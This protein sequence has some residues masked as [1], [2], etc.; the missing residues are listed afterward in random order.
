MK[1]SVITVC[2]NSIATL[3]TTILSVK[4]QTYEDIEYIV[5][6]GNSTDGSVEM[7]K[8]YDKVISKWSSEPDKGLYD[9]M[10]KGVLMATGEVIALINSDDLFC[11]NRALEKV[12][13]LFSERPNLKSVYADLYYVAQ[14]NTDK[15]VRKWKSG[16]QQS[17]Q[18]G[19]HPAHPTFYAKKELYMQY[20]MFNLNFKLAADFELM[21][22][23]LE[24][25]QIS[26]YYLQEYLVKMRLGGATNQSLK[27]ILE[28]N[29]ECL[30]A[31]KTNRLKVNSLMYPLRRT[32]PKL[33][34]FK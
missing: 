29:K 26:T 5:V 12:M 20:G 15:I 34:Q 8:K 28:G 27:N 13:Q 16:Q 14:N 31:F 25:H 19:W 32:I 21:L 18:S 33:L 3:E 2:F 9:A 24:K 4:N 11:D 10:N 6:D 17:F 1:I 22:R 30:R 7:I 23:F